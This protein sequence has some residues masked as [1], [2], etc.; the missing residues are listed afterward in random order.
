MDE[1]VLR[2]SEWEAVEVPH[3][4]AAAVVCRSHYAK[5]A[6]KQSASAHGLLRVGTN[7]LSGAALWMPPTPP[8]ARSVAGD[9]DWHGV[10]CLSRFALDPEVP[11]NGASYFLAASMRLLDRTRWPVLLTY[12]DTRLGHT[13]AIYLATNWQF[14]GAVPGHP[15]WL[16]PDG[17]LRG[18]KRGPRNLTTEEMLAE[19][20]TMVP[21]RYPKL[22]FVHRTRRRPAPR[23]TLP[24]KA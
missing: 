17:E 10:L 4:Q 9:D 19:G 20:F 12:A 15:V 3:A 7:R 8:A 24:M 5:T 1:P 2:H 23:A 14:V 18:K 21:D 22:K 11:K 13:G 16:G 6:A